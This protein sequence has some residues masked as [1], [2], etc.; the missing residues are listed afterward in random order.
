MRTL[1]EA[2]DTLLF[3][4]MSGDLLHY[5][6]VCGDP[7]CRDAVSPFVDKYI[8]GRPEVWKT[9]DDS[10]QILGLAA[11]M[12]EL[13]DRACP[14]SELPAVR[15][16]GKV[17]RNGRFRA[18][19]TASLDRLPSGTD[20]LILYHT[21]CSSCIEEMKMAA[22]MMGVKIFCIDLKRMEEWV[23]GAHQQLMDSFDLSRLPVILKLSGKKIS[24]RGL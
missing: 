1:A 22:G 18:E 24:G 19:R 20:I 6:N 10:L 21:S 15:V 5:L 9:A 3:K 2:G 13:A 16:R 11:I 12:K 17:L 23:E 4:Q 8:Y 14:G 7:S